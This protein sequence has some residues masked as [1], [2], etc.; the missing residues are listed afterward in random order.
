MKKNNGI[1]KLI[2]LVVILTIFLYSITVNA[3]TD[4]TK[5]SALEK[6]QISEDSQEQLKDYY[7]ELLGTLK[8]DAKFNTISTKDNIAIINVSF[9]NKS[10]RIFTRL[11]NGNVLGQSTSNSGLITAK[12]IIATGNI[13]ASGFVI[14]EIEKNF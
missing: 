7:G 9:G 12:N 8:T 11:Y 6:L 5:Y 10:S 13:S 4:K 14:N 3:E 2:F 1:V